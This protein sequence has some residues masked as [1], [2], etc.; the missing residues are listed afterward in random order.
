M[1]LYGIKDDK[2]G[3]ECSRHERNEYKTVMG[4]PESSK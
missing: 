2:M 4:K 1:N 3:S